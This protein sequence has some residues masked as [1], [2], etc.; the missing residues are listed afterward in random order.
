MVNTAKEWSV[1]VRVWSPE[2]EPGEARTKEFNPTASTQDEAE[3]KAISKAKEGV[4]S[5]ID[6]WEDGY[7]IL[8]SSV[9]SE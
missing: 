6:S 1:I 8:E 3:Q 5:F 7:D 2:D 4:N 9:L